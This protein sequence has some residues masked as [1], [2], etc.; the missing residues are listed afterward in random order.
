MLDT[1]T[2][3]MPKQCDTPAPDDRPNRP[4]GADLIE[5]VPFAAEP[6]SLI[7]TQGNWCGDWRPN[8]EAETYV[9]LYR[10]LVVARALDRRLGLLQRSG[11]T[12]FIAPAAGHE[13]AQVGIAHAMRAGHDWL[14]PYYRDS[15][16]ALAL[17]MAPAELFAQ[18]M[19]TRADTAKARQMPCH[20]GSRDLHIFTAV[21]SIAGQV[22][23]AVGMAMAAQLRG[24]DAVTVTTFGDGATSEGDW[25]AALNMAAARAAPVLFACENNGYAISVPFATQTASANVCDKA[26]A[27]GLPG[28]RVDGMDVVSVYCVTQALLQRI[29]NGDGPALVEFDVYRYGPHSSA[30]DDSVYRSREEV[31]AAKQRDPI[32]RMRRFLERQELWDGAREERLQAAIK[33]EFDAAIKQAEAGG[34]QHPDAMFDDV[35]AERPWHLAQQSAIVAGEQ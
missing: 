33:A 16:M 2:D 32:D 30:D 14:F 1:R 26:R 9:T 34:K 15:A 7:D 31:E 23:P 11:R 4:A 18:H 19:A 21:S 20:P 8:I 10:K 28:Y 3:R 13:G 17:G 27:C 6:I 25:Y 22:P 29:R 12:S 5:L 35:Y 24:S